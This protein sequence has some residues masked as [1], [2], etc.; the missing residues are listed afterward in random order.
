MSMMLRHKCDLG[1]F[2][3][4]GTNK[5]RIYQALYTGLSCLV[6]PMSAYA[7]VQNSYS[8]GSA[9]EVYFKD[10]ADVKVSDKLTYNGQTFIVRGREAFTGI[11][12]V[13]YLKISAVTEN[14]H[15]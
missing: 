14:A 1:R 3:N 11:P 10:G 9:F 4:E 8:V 5:R 13:S 6:L 12:S 15:V 7:S 2:V